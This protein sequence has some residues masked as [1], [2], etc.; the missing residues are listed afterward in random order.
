MYAPL[1]TLGRG[2][3]EPIPQVWQAHVKEPQGFYAFARG[4]A[5]ERRP[6]PPAPTFLSP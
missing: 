2:S 1:A 4:G 5:S 3:L 6:A